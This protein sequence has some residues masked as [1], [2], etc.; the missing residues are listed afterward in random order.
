MSIKMRANK[1]QEKPTTALPGT[2][3]M[4]CRQEAKYS[5]VYKKNNHI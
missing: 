1:K 5:Q 2:L 3:Q 4:L